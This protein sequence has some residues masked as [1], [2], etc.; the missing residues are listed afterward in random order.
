MM[1]TYIIKTKG[2]LYCGKTN[3]L[4]RRLKEHLNEKSPHWFGQYSNRKQWIDIY[5]FD[6]DLEKQI[7]RAGCE[8]TIKLFDKFEMQFLSSDIEEIKRSAS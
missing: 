8:F 6:T 5:V 7:K 3:D 2:G 1:Q 4:N